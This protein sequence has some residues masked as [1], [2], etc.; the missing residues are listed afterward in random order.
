M[1]VPMTSPSG[2]ARGF[3]LT[4]W[5]TEAM[6]YLGVPVSYQVYI[7]HTLLVFLTTF[8]AQ[9]SLVTTTSLSWPTLWALIVSAASGAASA[10]VHYLF[11]V[12]KVD[13]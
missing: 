10:A 13:I 4:A 2:K 5:F 6:D 7:L 12:L 9:I 3:I 8:V 1:T 11:K